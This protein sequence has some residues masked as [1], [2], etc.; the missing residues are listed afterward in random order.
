MHMGTHKV[1]YVKVKRP[2]A[3]GRGCV[4]GK[5]GAVADPSRGT[6]WKGLKRGAGL[7]AERQERRRKK[8]IT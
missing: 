1:H 4:G 3:T 6:K 7:L 5:A 8:E 2:V